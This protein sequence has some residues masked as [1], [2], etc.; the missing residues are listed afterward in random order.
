MKKIFYILKKD[1]LLLTLFLPLFAFAQPKSLTY[2]QTQDVN[3]VEQYKN[4]TIIDSYTTKDGVIIKIGDTLSIGKAM[5]KRE[6]YL[7]N[8]V[9]SHIVVGKNK[10]AINKDTR[11][12]PHNYS[13]NKVIV[14]SLFVTHEKFTGYKLRPKRKQMPLY[15]SAFVIE[16]ESGIS[17]IF[18]HSRKTIL[19]IEKAFSSGEIVSHNAQLSKVQKINKLVGLEGAGKYDLLLK[20]GK[21]KES[22][23]LTEEEF[24]KE[25]NKIL[26]SE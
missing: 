26:E 6:K 15:V 22:G 21:L 17:K 3:F 7:F 5:I 9:F 2:N 8:D 13:G 10:G 24:Q 18:S 11:Y 12:L 4:N 23:I 20:L 14:K 1:I 19:D 16:N 25:K